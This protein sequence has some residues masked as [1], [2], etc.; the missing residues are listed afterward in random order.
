MERS[1]HIKNRNRNLILHIV[2]CFTQSIGSNSYSG[3]YFHQINK[4]PMK[5]EI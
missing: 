5:K 1:F 2:T 4:N 3:L